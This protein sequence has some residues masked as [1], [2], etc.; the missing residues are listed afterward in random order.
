MLTRHLC[1]VFLGTILLVAGTL[2]G[3]GGKSNGARPDNEGGVITTDEARQI[4][5]EA[6]VF[7][8]AFVSNYRVYFPLLLAGDPL[9]QGVGFNEFAHNRQ[10]FPPETRD[11]TQRDTLF[12]LAILDLRREPIVISV[13]DVPQGQSY[14][15][16]MGDTSTETL[17]YISTLT[18]DNK[19]GDYVLVGPEFQGSVPAEHFDDLISTRG[20]F[21]V[22]NGRTII[23]DP[24]D[25]G[26]EHALQDGM[27]IRALSEFLGTEAPPE[28]PPIDFLAWDPE[29]AAGAGVFD[30]INMA[31]AWHPPAMSE[32]NAM[33]R[34]SR[35]GVVPGQPFT[36]EGMSDEVIAALEESVV[37]ANQNFDEQASQL[38]ASVG[39]WQ[40]DT[41]DISRF[42]TD[43]FRRSAQAFKTIYPNAPDH[44][45]YGQAYRDADGE[46]LTGEG[47]V[48]IRFEEGQLPPVEMFWSL[49][50]YDAK[51]TAM[52][53]NDAQRYSM[54]STTKDLTYS[55]DGSLTL[56][57]QHDA[58]TDPKERANWLPS[59]K[60]DIYLVLRLY[61]A[62]PE[63]FDGEWTPPPVTKN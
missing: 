62:K 42:G 6:Y 36:T 9:F 52:H 22:I 30:Y 20:Q 57:I 31:L 19:A 26:A 21:V 53:P 43:Y 45:I 44:A 4:A 2:L 35:I 27:Q 32:L 17:P 50:L 47:G 8:S 60:G 48:R 1:V 34:F 23:A 28:P 16:Q 49:R 7:G 58:P 33:A 5:T 3:C 59:P 14:M 55:D 61:G 25:M 38:G 54:G 40:W 37:E 29:K 18:T 56:C 10:P 15:L 46:Q 41:S 12:S 39:S 63:V 13:P 51:T 11:T 24:D